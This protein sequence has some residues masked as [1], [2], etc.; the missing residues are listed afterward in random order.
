MIL[1]LKEILKR[2]DLL[3]YLVITQLKLSYVNKVLGYFWSLLDPLLMMAVYIVLVNFIFKRKD[4][5]FPVL[6]FSSLLAW[7]WFTFSLSGAVNSISGKSKIILSIRFPLAILPISGVF[8][9][10]LRYLFGILA[11]IPMLFIFNA[12]PTITILW[13]PFLVIV[14]CMFTLGLCLIVS[15]M[16]VYF[17]DMNNIIQF[18]IRIWFYASPILYT[19]RE[20]LSEKNQAILFILNPFAAIFTSYKAIFVWGKSPSGYMGWV[21]GVSL[22]V[23]FMGLLTFK[24]FEN[25]ITKDL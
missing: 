1:L 8:S 14:Q 10:L 15:V 25:R 6:I 7:Q 18:V 24:K 9:H 5:Q 16:G 20:A 23:L 19:A 11:L 21:F 22:I 12:N 2:K 13:F 4:P 3:K 17:K